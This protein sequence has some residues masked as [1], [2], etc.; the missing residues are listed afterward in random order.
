MATA[1]R[2]D[3]LERLLAERSL[4]LDG[5]MGTMVQ[6]AGLGEADFRGERF[7]D[8]PRDLQG[9]NELLVLTRPALIQEIHDAYLEAGADIIETNSFG[10]T[11][12]AQADYG[13]ESVVHELNVQAAEIAV[14]AAAHWSART[15]DRPRFAAG[16]VGPTN[17]T[18]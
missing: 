14:R 1:N 3:Q 15:P 8:H 11:R 10:S 7:A 16:A 6:Q 4:V 2:K 12:V 17:R 5:A 18:L 9:D 13:L